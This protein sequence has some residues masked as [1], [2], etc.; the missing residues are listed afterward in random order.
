MPSGSWN[1]PDGIIVPSCGAC[2][3]FAF[4]IQGKLWPVQF[5]EK[6]CSRRFSVILCRGVLAVK[7]SPNLSSLMASGLGPIGFRVP[8]VTR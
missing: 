4:L 7:V 5:S 2:W 1:A 3:R 8:G 6:I